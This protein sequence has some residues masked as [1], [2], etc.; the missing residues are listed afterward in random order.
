M[1]TPGALDEV[2]PVVQRLADAND[3]GES[4]NGA[5]LLCQVMIPW[6]A[7]YSQAE[8]QPQHL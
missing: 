4:C 2:G 8:I 1:H 7:T 5:A 3:V 6:P